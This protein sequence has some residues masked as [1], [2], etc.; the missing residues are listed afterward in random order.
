MVQAGVWRAC[1][2]LLAEIG[3]QKVK[4]PRL[5]NQTEVKS[6]KIRPNRLFEGTKLSTIPDSST[7]TP[8]SQNSVEMHLY[9]LRRSIPHTQ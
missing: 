9:N 7:K 1:S 4:K 3:S 6:S 5:V 8:S 2:A